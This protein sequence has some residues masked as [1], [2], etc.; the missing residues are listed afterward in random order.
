MLL[1][2]TTTT[3]LTTTTTNNNYVNNNNHRGGEGVVRGDGVRRY[4]QGSVRAYGLGATRLSPRASSCT[5]S[6]S[7]LNEEPAPP[8]MQEFV[9]AY[10]PHAAGLARPGPTAKRRGTTGTVARR[11]RR[12]GRRGAQNRRS[13]EEWIWM[14]FNFARAKHILLFVL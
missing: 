11:D 3:T 2:T 8:P 6:Q 10:L 7:F 1:A 14:R 12:A 13:T 9:P 4:G 5:G